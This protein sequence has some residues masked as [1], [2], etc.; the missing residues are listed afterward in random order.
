[1][2]LTMLGASIPANLQWKTL[3]GSFIAM[4][5]TL[6]AQ[7]FAAQ[8]AR[9]QAIFTHA[10]ALKLDPNADINTGWPDH[11]VSA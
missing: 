4:T 6:A 1:M 7:L 11:Y 3:D 5:Q 9:E 2:A 8:I 10:E